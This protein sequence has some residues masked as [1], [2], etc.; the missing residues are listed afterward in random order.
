MLIIE[1]SGKGRKIMTRRMNSYGEWALVAGA[2]EGVGEGFTRYLLSMGMKVLMV[3]HQAE[4][5][6]RFSS[7][8]AIVPGSVQTVHLDLA[9]TDAADQC[10]DAAS[11]I[12]CGLLVYVAAFSRV[13][14]FLK[15]TPDDLDRYL[16]VNA[17]T[18]IRLVHGFAGR[19]IRRGGGGIL[20][21][22]SLA[23]LI[24]PP[25]VAPYAATKGF[26]LILAESLH[27][28][29]KP[30]GI[31]VTACCA[32]VTNTP[33][34][35]SS[36]PRFGFFKPQIQQPAEVARY[37]MRMIGRKAVCISGTGNRLSYFILSWLLPRS[38]AGRIMRSNMRALYPDL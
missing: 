33:A 37:G 23:G 10:L 38:V 29:L 20:L 19:F 27:H 36:R 30:S 11:G 21:I 9:D 17:R 35:R 1:I 15:N 16:D 2:A 18:M 3:D 4:A 22:S 26:T 34:F 28:E 14:P 13:Q 7:D 31:D 12:D 6:R 8:P 24:G 25:L 5:L 32:G